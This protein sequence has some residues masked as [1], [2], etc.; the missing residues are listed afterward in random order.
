MIELQE[1]INRKAVLVGARMS[2]DSYESF[3]ISMEELK[4]LAEACNLEVAGE[5]RQNMDTEDSATF[6]GIGKVDE[7][8]EIIDSTGADAVVF[9]NTLSPSQLNNLGNALKVEILDR[10]GL[11]LNIF[12]KRAR[13]KEAR[14]QVDYA[15][16]KYMLPR[17]VGLR[18]NLSRQGGTGG[19]LSNKGSGEKQIELDRRRIEKEMSALRRGLKEIEKTREVQRKHR[20]S[21]GIPLVSLVGYTNA[22][23]S[24]LLNRLIDDYSNE[25]GQ[26][27]MV[28]DMLF[29][30][31]DTTVRR[32]SP[33]GHREFL[34][35]D[36]VGFINDL[37]TDLVN[38]FHSTLEEAL[39][40]DLI[41]EVVDYSDPNYSMH[42]DVT[43][44]TLRELG[45]GTIPR[46]TVLNKAEKVLDTAD[47]PRMREDR[48]Y[49]SAHDGIGMEEL[50][51]L[52]D[53]KLNEA[54]E[55]MELLI[56]YDKSGM[57]NE[58]RSHAQILNTDYRDNGIY[59]EAVMK[60]EYVA[61]YKPFEIG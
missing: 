31:L 13:T 43:D 9:N 19:S 21:S 8:R 41:L 16:L 49:I 53:D 3:D 22:G 54:A 30:T 44:R 52:I 48:I 14:M 7:V 38:A 33:A 51:K 1:T 42:M 40:A 27:V 39:Y 56:P 57:E 26:K 4:G 12:G 37:P 61:K 35:S 28:K 58:L 29:A 20:Q 18:S 46:I 15:E 5:A 2:T 50:L 47:L 17:L 10:T 55:R 36:T 45:A 11:I 59:I 24:T 60:K 32:I 25:A 23:K 6:I 34:L